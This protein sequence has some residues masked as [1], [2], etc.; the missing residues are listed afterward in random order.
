MLSPIAET[1]ASDRSRAGRVPGATHLGCGGSRGDGPYVWLWCRLSGDVIEAVGYE[2]NGCPSSM[3][4]G[5]ALSA[6]AEGRT[7]AQISLLEPEELVRFLGGLPEGKEYYADLAIS[8]IRS[9]EP[10]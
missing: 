8:A 6:L 4:I 10:I 1:Y 5:G 9:L 2:C 7:I 3:A